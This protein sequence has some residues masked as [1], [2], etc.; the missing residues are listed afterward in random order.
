MQIINND[1]FLN[2]ELITDQEFFSLKEKDLSH[3]P[4]IQNLK[5]NTNY[6]KLNIELSI[7][8]VG[9]NSFTLNAS[10]TGDLNQTC[11]RCIR[12]FNNSL[13]TTFEEILL[14]TV[15]SSRA[16]KQEASS[17]LN[18]KKKSKSEYQHLDLDS[19]VFVQEITSYKFPLTQW[20]YENIVIAINEKQNLCKKTDCEEVFKNLLQSTDI[21]FKA[22]QS[23]KQ[24]NTHKVFADLLKP[25]KKG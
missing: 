1:G 21:E 15:K 7:T 4:L 25:L 9:D 22:T 24:A 5:D 3:T 6:T 11:G 13:I 18:T 23:P 14:Y 2:L 17:S 12:E 16:R 10:V 19:N 8:S 20:L